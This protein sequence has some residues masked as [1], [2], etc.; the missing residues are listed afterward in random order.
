MKT[1]YEANPKVLFCSFDNV[2][3]PFKG[4]SLANT[5]EETSIRTALLKLKLYFSAHSLAY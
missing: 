1:N 4:A 3:V 2:D 5:T